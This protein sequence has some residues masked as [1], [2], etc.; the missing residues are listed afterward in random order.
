MILQEANEL[1]LIVQICL[2]VPDDRSRVTLLEAII[3]RFVVGEIE[4]LLLELVFP[5]PI[6]LCNVNEV[7]VDFFAFLN[8][9][10]PE[11]P[12]GPFLAKGS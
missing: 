2:E 5:I 10:D 8:G 1:V 11:L 12:L 9:R 7:F 4:A 3:K 6:T